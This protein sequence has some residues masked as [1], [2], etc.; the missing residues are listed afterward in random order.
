MSTLINIGV[1]VLFS[2]SWW[3]I[4]KTTYG[5]YSGVSYLI[6]GNVE[7]QNDKE[8]RELMTQIKHQHEMLSEMK[9]EIKMLRRQQNGGDSSD[10]D[11]EGIPMPLTLEDLNED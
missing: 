2:A 11:E 8:R 1:D 4:R 9:M 3:V 7:T 6:W 5:I 10:V